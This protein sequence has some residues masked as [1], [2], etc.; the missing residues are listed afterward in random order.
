[1]AKALGATVASTVT[2]AAVAEWQVMGK[3]LSRPNGRDLVTGAHHYPSDISRPGMLH[4]KIL[5]APAYGTKMSSVDV[6]SAKAMKDV[7]VVQDG[8]FVGVAAPTTFAAEKA[9]EEIAKDAKWETAP[10]PSSKELYDYLRQK[11][12]GGVP[13]N[14]FADDVAKAA[15]SVKGTYH[16]A[17]IQHAP[18]EPRAAVAEWSEGKLTVWTSTQNPFG[19]RSEL[20]NALRIPEDRVRVIVPDF[21]GGFGGKHSGECAVEAAKLAQGAGKPVCLR[22]T[23]EE[24]FTWAYFRPAA[25]IDAEAGRDASG[26]A[27]AWHFISIKSGGSA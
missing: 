22:W 21:G 15:K 18:M 2:V 24:E 14:P 4:G 3:P 16:V 12:R 13:A 6:G 20:A 27:S 19:V 25:V 23:R 9:I 26:A 7:T 10:H 17:Y 5:R 11:A 8:N 1:A